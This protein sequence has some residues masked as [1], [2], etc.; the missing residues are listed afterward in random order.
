MTHSET[1]GIRQFS[2]LMNAVGVFGVVGLDRLLCFK[3]VRELQ[4]LVSLVRVETSGLGGHL[5]A[6]RDQLHPTTSVP[7]NPDKFYP[8]AGFKLKKLFTAIVNPLC[9]IGQLQ[10][11][12]RFIASLLNVI[13]FSF[14]C[15]GWSHRLITSN[16]N[17]NSLP[18][19]LIPSNSSTLSRR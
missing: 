4:D 18:A 8:A 10:L 13:S 14:S 12:R 7:Q 19:K 5:T 2:L 9:V 3:I 1:I 11:L 17:H 16:N 6:V 15:F